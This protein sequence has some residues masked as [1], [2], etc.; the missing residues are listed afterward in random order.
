GFIGGIYPTKSMGTFGFGWLRIGTG[1]L[2]ERDENANELSKFGFSQQALI[3]SY[4]K[5]LFSSVSL[6]TNFKFERTSFSV[7][8]LSDSGIGA[9]LGVIY[10]PIFDNEL[11]QDL[12]LGLSIQNLIQARTKLVDASESSPMNLKIGVAKP[13]RIGEERDALTFLVDFNKGQRATGTLH[14]GGE[15][16]FREQAKLRLGL[17]DGVFAFGAGAVYNNFHFDYTFGK[18]FDGADFSA[19]H[20]FSI[21]ID[22]GKSKS[23]LIRI[24]QE[25]RERELQVRVEDQLWFAR[26]AEFNSNM[27]DGR[28]KYYGQDYLG[29]YVN[30]SSAEEAATAL[31]EIA[32]KARGDQFDDP[33]ANMRVETANSSLAEAQDMLN[34][35]SAKNDSVRISEIRRIAREETESKLENEL[36]DF[37]LRHKDQG[38]VLFKNGLYERAVREWQSALDR[39]NEN[40]TNGNTLPSWV[41]DVRRQLEDNIVMAQGKLEGDIKEAI[42]RADQMAKSGRFVQAL[43]EL[44]KIRGAATTDAD[45]K[46]IDARIS[47]YRSQSS[48]QQSYDQGVRAYERKDWKTAM[49]AFERALE[50]KPDHKAAKKY[51]SDARAR[52]LATN[53]NMPPKVRQ[54]YIEGRRLYDAGKYGEAL[55]VWEEALKEQPYNKRLLD[56]IDNAKE[57]LK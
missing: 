43:E 54:K 42:A 28:E 38:V 51:Y 40:T 1:D 13:I 47:S 46:T 2:V 55:Q 30:F 39:I 49:G 53:Q 35:S 9:D 7:A 48:F 34:R 15:Y 14:L 23:E 50:F 17:N 45:R 27:Q 41:D 11:L 52:S 29:A 32:M 31:V 37:I 10:R 33:E 36:R 44:S 6:G 25:E 12:S 26:E 18:L 19:N 20:R 5:Q 21:T 22:I 56:S 16:S 4:G 24:A 8:N 57:R 3:V